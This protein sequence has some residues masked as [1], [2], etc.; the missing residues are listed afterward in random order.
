MKWSILKLNV[1]CDENGCNGKWPKAK[2]Q[3][4]RGGETERKAAKRNLFNPLT[5]KELSYAT[6][7]H[8]L[9]LCVIFCTPFSLAIH[10]KAKAKQKVWI[11]NEKVI[12]CLLKMHSRRVSEGKTHF[13]C[14]EIWL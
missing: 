5:K 7:C 12:F 14:C 9:M 4:K 10:T 6:P 1:K 8:I 13:S 2:S 3:N 11:E